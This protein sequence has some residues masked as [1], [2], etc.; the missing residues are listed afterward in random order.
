M[1]AQQIKIQALIHP[2]GSVPIEKAKSVNELQDEMA[3]NLA[4]V[5][6]VACVSSRPSSAS[7]GRRW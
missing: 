5:L 3:A 4:I 2:A 6:L 7:Y 1:I